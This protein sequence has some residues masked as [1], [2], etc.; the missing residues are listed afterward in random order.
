MGLKVEG[1]ERAVRR[2]SFPG[3]AAGKYDVGASSFTDTKER[4]KTVDFVDLLHRRRVVLH[5]GVG[6]RRRSAGLSDLCGHTVA[7]EK[8]TTEKTDAT[9][10][11]AKC[12]KAGKPGVTVLVFPDQNGANLALVERPRTARLRRLPGRRLPGQEVRRH[13]Q[14]RRPVDR[15]RSVRP[16]DPEERAG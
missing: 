16:R 12:K 15:Q 14:A 6:R 7:V 9:N 1:R 3:L 8:G 2:A 4:E 11:G 5:E 10:Q 13:V